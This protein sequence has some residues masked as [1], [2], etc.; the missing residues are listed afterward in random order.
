MARR[1]VN[2]PYT[3]TF[4]FGEPTS[5]AK[6]GRHSGVDYGVATGSDVFAPTSGVITDY[7]NGQYHGL[8]VQIFDGRHYHRMM[9]NSSVLVSPGN[10]VS[11]GQVVARSGATGQG[12]TGPHVHWDICTEK[13][14]TSFNSFISPA[15]WLFGSPPPPAPSGSTLFLPSSVEKWRVYN[16]NG[17]F[18][19]GY[20]K[21]FI[22]PSKF[23]PGL[24]YQILGN[25]YPHLYDIQTEMFG[26]VTI[27]AGP[28]TVA[29]FR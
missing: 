26:K 16:L 15:T 20:E 5:T 7:T 4:T 12:V 9:H 22:W 28:D 18:R 2:S 23:P 27:Y 13:I 17:P 3:I 25:R 10:R 19:P 1:P 29:Q 24:S 21:A 8:V 14:P 11:E 6:F